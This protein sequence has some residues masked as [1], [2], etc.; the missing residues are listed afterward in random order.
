MTQDTELFEPAETSSGPPPLCLVQYFGATGPGP[1]P[2]SL[3]RI[4]ERDG[5]LLIIEFAP[6]PKKADARTKG[7]NRAARAF[8]ALGLL[9][10][11]ASV[12]GCIL[13]FRF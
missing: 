9:L 3:G 7:R 6:P 10:L 2:P 4:A 1:P 12:I 5:N 8:D 13:A 11:L